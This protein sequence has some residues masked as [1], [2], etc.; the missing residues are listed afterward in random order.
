MKMLMTS[1]DLIC[2]S[3]LVMYEDVDDITGFNMLVP[4]LY[5]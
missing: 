2:W 1:L 3:L 5:V 4:S